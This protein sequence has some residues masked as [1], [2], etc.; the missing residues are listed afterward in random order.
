MKEAAKMGN[1]NYSLRIDWKSKVDERELN[2]HF[3]KST[4]RSNGRKV[5]EKKNGRTA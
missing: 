3:A 1:H 4:Q 5:I 2:M